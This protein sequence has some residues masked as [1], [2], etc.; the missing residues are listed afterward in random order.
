MKTPK[1]YLIFLHPNLF[2]LSKPILVAYAAGAISAVLYT[3]F[4]GK[5][6]LLP[7]FFIQLFC[8]TS[9]PIGWLS[10]KFM[11]CGEFGR[12]GNI[13]PVAATIE[14]QRIDILDNYE[15]R[16]IFGQM[17]RVYSSER[18]RPNG[19][20]LH[21]LNRL[22]GRGTSESVTPN[23]DQ[24]RQLVDMG[25]GSREDVRQ[26]LQQCGNNASEAANLLL[27]NRR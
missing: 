18:A 19:S 5:L 8:S 2:E 11:E 21:F 10:Q 14:R 4:F 6:N 15:R 24:V 1:L 9:N 23:E 13:L 26:A 20:Q 17:Q 25:L 3:Q 27:H 22:L 7:H 12:E 16:L